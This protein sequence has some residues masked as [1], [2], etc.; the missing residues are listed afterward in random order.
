MASQPVEVDFFLM[1]GQRVSARFRADTRL[2][3][4]T[5]RHE[6]DRLILLHSGE[7]DAGEISFEAP[8]QG[9]F[10]FLWSLPPGVAADA[11]MKVQL[12]GQAMVE[13]WIP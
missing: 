6:G 4:N 3:F 12:V 9:T 10:S 5:H 1:R 13:R 2:L 11:K 8:H 7:G